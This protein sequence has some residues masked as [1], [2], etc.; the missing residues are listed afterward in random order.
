MA[1]LTPE[2]YAALLRQGQ[3]Q[4]IGGQRAA[5]QPMSHWTQALASALNQG[6]GAARQDFARTGRTDATTAGNEMLAAGMGGDQAALAEALKNP[7]VADQARQWQ[8][9]A[10]ARA[11][12]ADAAQRAQWAFE[13]EKQNAP[14]KRQ[15]LELA[16]QYRQAQINAQNRPA[17][18]KLQKIGVDA[19]N[20]P[21]YGFVGPDGSVRPYEMPAPQG[22]S[23]APTAG[24]IPPGLDPEL[25]EIL[26]AAPPQAGAI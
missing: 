25:T 3:A 5:G 1:Y 22:A 19:Y 15:Q 12:A 24:G 9:Q 14:L 20:R 6:F 10:P 4:Q 21:Q 26:K 18:P 2:D 11:R 23:P 13:Q 17:V 16:N 8:A 7:F